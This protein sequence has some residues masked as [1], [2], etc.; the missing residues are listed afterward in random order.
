MRALLLLLFV[1]GSG[2]LARAQESHSAPLPTPP[3][4]DLPR[5]VMELYR[6]IKRFDFDE[7]K[8]GNYE[9]SPM[10][11]ERL[12]GVGLPPF[13]RGEFDETTGHDAP[14]SFKLSIATGNVAY[15]YRESDLPIVPESDYLVVGFCRTQGLKRAAAMVMAEVVDEFGDPIHRSQAVSNLIRS[16]AGT[17]D[18]QRFE[19]RISTDDP[20]AL[21]LHLQLWVLQDSAWQEPDPET[22]DPIIR[23]DVRAAAWFDDIAVYRMPRIRVRLANATGLVPF[24]E[25]PRFELAVNIA[26]G[27]QLATELTVE[28]MQGQIV[29]TLRHGIVGEDR[30]SAKTDSLRFESGPQAAPGA[31]EEQI[32]SLAASPLEPGIYRAILRVLGRSDALLERRLQFAVLEPDRAGRGPASDMGVLLSAGMRAD[33][34]VLPELF[35]DLRC[36]AAKIE[37]PFG[38]ENTDPGRSSPL[39]ATARLVR[40]LAQRQIEV[41]GVLCGE[42]TRTGDRVSL[43]HRVFDGGAWTRQLSQILAQLGA[44]ISQWQLGPELA[45]LREGEWSVNQVL[46]IR[47]NFRRILSLPELATPVPLLSASPCPGDIASLLASADI[48]TK[49]L[50]VLLEERTAENRERTWIQIESPPNGDENWRQIDLARRIALAKAAGARRIFVPAPF[51]PDPSGDSTWEPTADYQVVRAAFHE[52]GGRRA[53][54]VLYPTPDSLMIL[55]ES[56]GD[57][58]AVVWTWR[59]QPVDERVEYWFGQNAS[60][61]DFRG[62]PVTLQRNGKRTIVPLRPEPVYI[63]GIDVA[64]LRLAQS[65]SVTPTLIEPQRDSAN[66]VLSFENTYAHTL[67]GEIRAVAP[68]NWK[69]D[70]RMLRFEL[71]PGE[72]LSQSYKLTAPPRR[73]ANILPFQFDIQIE[74][75]DTLNF[76][77]PMTISLR[78]LVMTGTVRLENGRT[79]VEQ[80]LSN[81]SNRVASFLAYMDPPRGKR[82]ESVFRELKPGATRTLVYQLPDAITPQQVVSLSIREIGGNRTLD[83]LVK[84]PDSD[85]NP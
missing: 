63:R 27:Q 7:R 71:E 28:D 56:E 70:P 29:Q 60:A 6:L 32:L 50:A 75:G 58:E 35:A 47:Q 59:D 8:L 22:P 68:D 2:G 10:H 45:E 57:G 20:R 55:Y 74:S 1:L 39:L 12:T 62:V 38:A 72:V 64:L 34:E 9:S 81:R 21:A 25:S 19:L 76:E 37:I 67:R 31:A 84:L 18:W 82:Q 13:A 14:P 46:G 40:E 41:I 16:G 30:H 24:G 66:P 65:F 61:I 43:R 48:P 85:Q 49:A 4:A 5:D 42:S 3:A 11:W 54:A 51:H 44:L 53:V 80:T 52:L 17:S 78:D 69:I 77:V 23:D 33:P 83:M 79:L 15:E 26:A 36:R 73:F